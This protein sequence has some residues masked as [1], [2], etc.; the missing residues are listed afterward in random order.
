MIQESEFTMS[1]SPREVLNVVATIQISKGD[2]FFPKLTLATKDG[3]EGIP[4][5]YI[6]QHNTNGLPSP[7]HLNGDSGSFH[8]FTYTK[9]CFRDFNMVDQA[10]MAWDVVQH[11]CCL[12][13]F[14]FIYTY[15]LAKYNVDLIEI[16]LF[17]V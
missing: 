17:E 14:T 11:K 12:N 6:I 13:P 8:H 7:R 5:Y 1:A 10:M 15:V 4:E 9:V 16:G 2:V 3:A